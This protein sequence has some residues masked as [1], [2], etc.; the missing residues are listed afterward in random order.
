MIKV[1][2]GSGFAEVD[3][4]NAAQVARVTRHSTRVKTGK[5]TRETV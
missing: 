4:P 1:L 2:A 3:F 5:R